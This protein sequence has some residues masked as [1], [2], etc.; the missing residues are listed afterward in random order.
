MNGWGDAGSQIDD[1]M[2]RRMHGWVNDAQ[3]QGHTAESYYL[4]TRVMQVIKKAA[5]RVK[6]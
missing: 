6:R 1:W 5:P 4:Y 3:S 2:D